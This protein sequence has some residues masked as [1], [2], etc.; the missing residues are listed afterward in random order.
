M[1]VKETKGSS[2][3]MKDWSDGRKVHLLT[4]NTYMHVT[5][6]LY[7]LL[8]ALSISHIMKHEIIK[9]INIWMQGVIFRQHAVH[10]NFFCSQNILSALIIVVL[11]NGWG[12]DI[13]QLLS[14]FRVLFLFVNFVEW[15]E[16]ILWRNAIRSKVKY[17]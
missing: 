15:R 12:Q 1:P 6:H 14:F 16:F 10:T 7:S 17:F 3:E 11:W 2:K 8:Q 4:N 9:E 13:G 5:S